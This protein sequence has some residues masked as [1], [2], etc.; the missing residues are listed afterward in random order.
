MARRQIVANSL[1]KSTNGFHT[2]THDNGESECSRS[3]D[4]AGN[5]DILPVIGRKRSAKASKEVALAARHRARDGQG[6]KSGIQQ[7]RGLVGE[8]AGGGVVDVL[9]V[10]KGGHRLGGDILV[11]E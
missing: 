11:G 7:V 10:L 9:E 2:V 4:E 3:V 8:V 6:R 1:D 5:G